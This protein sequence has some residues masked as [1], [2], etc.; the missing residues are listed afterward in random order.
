MLTQV[1]LRSIH[2]IKRQ[3]RGIETDEMANGDSIGEQPVGDHF[4]GSAMDDVFLDDYQR[5]AFG[6]LA[7]QIGG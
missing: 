7:Q 4:A 3:S 6:K 5:F 2:A 1:L